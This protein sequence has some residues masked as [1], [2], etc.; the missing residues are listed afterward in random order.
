MFFPHR[1]LVVCFMPFYVCGHLHS[2]LV[3]ALTNLCAL[4]WRLHTAPEDRNKA[5]TPL[6]R[7]LSVVSL[8]KTF[9]SD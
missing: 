5:T 2:K 7:I 8:T 4:H 6:S 1:I 9:P 3:K